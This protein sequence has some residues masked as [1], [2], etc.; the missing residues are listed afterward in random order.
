MWPTMP[1]PTPAPAPNVDLAPIAGKLDRLVEGQDRIADL[2][3]AMHQQRPGPQVPVVPVEPP[4][5]TAAQK[6]AEEAKAEAAAVGEASQQAVKEVKEESSR[7]REAVVALVGDQ[8]TLKERFEARLA[9][10]K[11]ELGEDAS[12]RDIA[13]AYV[14]DLAQEKLADGTL[15]LTGGKILGG[16]LGLSGPLAFAL[17]LGLWM[18]S[19]RIG[20]KVEAG[21]PLVI[22]RVFDRLG[23]KIDDLRNRLHDAPAAQNTSRRR[24]K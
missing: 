18:L 21:D 23:D 5:D 9:K 2:L 4:P 8:E 19:R 13:R 3:D 17:G 22:Q 11:E 16:A 20:A 24:A 7:L 12:R 14:K 1:S 15:G 10:V 6:A